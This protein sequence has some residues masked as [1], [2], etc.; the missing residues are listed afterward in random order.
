M[1]GLTDVLCEACAAMGWK[2]PTSI[3]KE[4][5]PLAFEGELCPVYWLMRIL[6]GSLTFSLKELS[7]FQPCAQL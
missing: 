4:A 7:P 6:S 1:Q 3:Q 5:L 2:T